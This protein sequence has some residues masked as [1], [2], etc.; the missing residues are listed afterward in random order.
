MATNKEP[1]KREANGLA[2]D[3]K[4][5]FAPGNAGGGRKPLEPG[6]KDMLLPLGKKAV[7]ALQ[8]VLD[9]PEAKAADK[10]RAAEIVMD[11]LLGKA[12]QPIIADVPTPEEHMT[13]SEMMQAARELVRGDDG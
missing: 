6:V 1:S 2:R 3:N 9:D 7:T 5:R 8:N 4:G 11:R 10:L 12:A 13:L